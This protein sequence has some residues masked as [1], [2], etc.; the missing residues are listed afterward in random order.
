MANK[1]DRRKPADS[2]NGGADI[3]PGDEAQANGT[4]T[5]EEPAPPADPPR[6]HSPYGYDPKQWPDRT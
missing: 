6:R 2:E 4:P 1:P 3:R 5:P